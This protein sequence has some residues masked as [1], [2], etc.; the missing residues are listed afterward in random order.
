M[1]W[2]VWKRGTIARVRRATP[3]CRLLVRNCKQRLRRHGGRMVSSPAGWMV[4]THGCAHSH[5]RARARTARSLSRTVRRRL[6][7]SCVR[8]SPRSQITL[9]DLAQSRAWSGRAWSRAPQPLRRGRQ[10][11]S[12]AR[13]RLC[14]HRGQQRGCALELWTAH[15]ERSRSMGVTS[16]G[17]L[18]VALLTSRGSTYNS[19][20]CC[21]PRL[22][23][24]RCNR[25]SHTTPAPHPHAR[26]MDS[27]FRTPPSVAGR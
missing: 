6:P 27:L 18:Q 22:T 1:I 24:A 5:A 16:R 13:F 20:M 19:K 26:H 15:G 21:T 25:G 23:R 9:S 12:S 11:R 3:S 4:S 14:P 2:A 10:P 8:R 17:S 7:S